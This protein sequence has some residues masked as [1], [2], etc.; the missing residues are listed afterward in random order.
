ME[1][2]ATGPVT[3]YGATKLAGEQ[4]V[5]AAADDHLILRTAWIYAPSGRNFVRTMLR[6]AET[7]GDEVAVAV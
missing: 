6:L 4:A 2:D 7:R 5:A 1:V 3:V